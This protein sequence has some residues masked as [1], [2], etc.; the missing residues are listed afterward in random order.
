MGVAGLTITNPRFIIHAIAKQM[1]KFLTI[2]ARS[3]ESRTGSTTE[4]RTVVCCTKRRN[5]SSGSYAQNALTPASSMKASSKIRLEGSEVMDSRK[6]KR[7]ARNN[8]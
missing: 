2:K 7:A 1:N 3:L 8:E 5:E 6:R 4:T